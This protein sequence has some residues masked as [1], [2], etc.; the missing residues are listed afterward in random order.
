MNSYTFGQP[1]DHL[2][3][4]VV[5][6]TTYTTT[7]PL[8]RKLLPETFHVYHSTKYQKSFVVPYIHVPVSSTCRVGQK[9]GV[10]LPLLTCSLS[11]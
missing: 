6:R 10:S 4:S 7:I 1:C 3:Y 9:L 2:E 11:A 5:Y 8:D